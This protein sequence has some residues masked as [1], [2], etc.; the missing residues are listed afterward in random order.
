[1]TVDTTALEERKQEIEQYS[2]QLVQVETQQASSR[3]RIEEI[4]AELKERGYDPTANLDEQL[5][6]QETELA[7]LCTSIDGLLKD[8]GTRL[9]TD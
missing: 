3:T 4:D 2:R 5:T 6:T 9:S 8:I 1:M 7:T